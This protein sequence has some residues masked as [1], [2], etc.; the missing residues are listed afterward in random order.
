MRI[1]HQVLIPRMQDGEHADLGAQML[2]V[3]RHHAERFRSSLKQDIVDDLLIL[4]SDWYS[5]T[6]SG[7]IC[8]GDLP[9]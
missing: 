4:Q 6:S 7:P 9:K 3:G 2:G 1:L 5:R 8:S